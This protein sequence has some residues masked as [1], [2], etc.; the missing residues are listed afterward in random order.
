MVARVAFEGETI[1][2][3]LAAELASQPANV[4]SAAQSSS[5]VADP[6]SPIAN[7]SNS[8][9]DSL[10]AGAYSWRAAASSLSYGAVR[11]WYRYAAILGRIL[12]RPIDSLAPAAHA[13][14]CVA[15]FE[16]E[17][18]QT[19]P[20]AVVD[21]AVDTMRHMGLAR[22]A[23]L[24]NAVLRRYL[25]EREH[26][27]AMLQQDP[28]AQ[29]ACP[30]WLAAQWRREWPGHWRQFLSSSDAKPPLW[31]RVNQRR[32]RPGEYLEQ[33]RNA[34]IEAVES[35]NVP[36]AVLLPQPRRVDE[37]PG[38]L[39]GL[40]SVQ[41]VN[42]QLAAI[43]LALASGQR[44]L[45]ACAAPGG[46][47]G[48]IAERAPALEALTAIDHDAARLEKVRENLARLHVGAQVFCADAG[49]PT[50]GWWDGTPFDRILL[51]APC[52]ALGVIRRHPDIRVR[53]TPHDLDRF[54][55]S[56]LRL[57]I[58]AWPLLAR[59]GRLVYSTCTVT[60]REN[61]EV[62][63]AFVAC[64]PDAAILP[65]SAWTNWPSLGICDDFGVQLV[66]GEAG[67]DGF[68]YAALVKG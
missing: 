52:S 21:A 35:E 48:L 49:A 24:C 15:L 25:R 27:A 30:A 8:I 67:G 55:A 37:L 54:A 62:L 65:V 23:G 58:G 5:P 10:R 56:Q 61:R 41:D 68:Y 51:D 44:V 18:E 31:L 47:T 43:P 12:S 4:P 36:G 9:A 40:A 13:V 33:L 42:A 39:Q 16:L 20:Y 29:F 63:A 38:F 19:P 45:D 26:I 28:A 50:H 11:G 1:E 3:A 6:S 34:G 60:W 2:R 46:K 32:I 59:G 57:L 17:D 14:L 53:R 66:P 64:T 7:P 22:M